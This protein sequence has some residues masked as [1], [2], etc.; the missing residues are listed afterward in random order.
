M[1]LANDGRAGYT[2]GV[3]GHLL[4]VF[5]CARAR[6]EDLSARVER[7]YVRPVLAAVADAVQGRESSWTPPAPLESK[8]A[9]ALGEMISARWIEPLLLGGE[10]YVFRAARILASPGD[11]SLPEAPSFAALGARSRSEPFATGAPRFASPVDF[12][13]AASRRVPDSTSLV[14]GARVSTRPRLR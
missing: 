6:A 12:T 9:R 7:D 11:F 5:F 2:A 14:R 4:A 1:T 3:T 13:Y 10:A 8:R